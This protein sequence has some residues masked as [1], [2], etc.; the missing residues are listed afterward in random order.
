VSTPD[1]ISEAERVLDAA[2]GYVWD[3]ERLPVPVEDIAD[4]VFGL[5]VRD[6]KDMATAPGA[7]ALQ[8]GQALSGLLLPGRGEIWVNADEARQWP[9]RRRFTIGHELGHWV[10]HRAP[11]RSRCSASA[12]AS[13][14]PH[15]SRTQIGISRRRPARSPPSC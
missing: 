7:P 2:P 14:S 6:V 8:D 9:P 13:T 12:P 3:G 15:R 11:G 1:V 4:S 5:L 10:M